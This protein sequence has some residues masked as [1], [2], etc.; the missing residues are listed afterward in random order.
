MVLLTIQVYKFHLLLSIV[1]QIYQLKWLPTKIHSD[2]MT[3]NV[4]FK[5]IPNIFV[6]NKKVYL[7]T[8]TTSQ[9]QNNA[10]YNKL[11]LKISAKVFKILF[12]T[13]IDN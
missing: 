10:S 6:H 3:F 8:K 4:R 12:T 2:T 1:Q 5:I 9:L 11:P 7:C 13:I